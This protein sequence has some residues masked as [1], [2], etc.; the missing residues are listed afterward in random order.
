MLSVRCISDTMGDDLPV[1]A[2]VLLEPRTGRPNPLKLF[3][4][5]MRYPS[6]INGFN[7]LLKN[8]RIA[9]VELAKGLEEILPQLVRI[10]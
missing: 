5:M 7:K 1:P 2:E 3:R 8:S 4:Y 10:S 6:C 9:Q